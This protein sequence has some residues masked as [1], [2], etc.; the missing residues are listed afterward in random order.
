VDRLVKVAQR[1][2]ADCTRHL[3]EPRV[4]G[5][6]LAAVAQVAKLLERR[7][8]MSAL[9]GCLDG[10]VSSEEERCGERER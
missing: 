5:D 3:E 9:A 8:A 10:S 1:I 7:C 6:K 2:V 4:V